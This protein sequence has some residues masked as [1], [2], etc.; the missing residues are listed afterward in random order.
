MIP[1]IGLVLCTAW[2][3]KDKDTTDAAAPIPKIESYFDAAYVASTGFEDFNKT[4][5]VSDG[6]PVRVFK[7]LI[8]DKD[9]IWSKQVG[10]NGDDVPGPLWPTPP[11]YSKDGMGG[12]VLVQNISPNQW[13][14]KDFAAVPQPYDVYIVLRENQGVRYEG[15]FQVGYGLRDRGSFLEL[16]MN[17]STGGGS[18]LVNMSPPTIF[19]PYKLAI[20]R[21]R[22]DGAKSKLW[23]NDVMIPPGEVNLGNAQLTRLGYGTPSHADQHD[24]YGMWVKFGTLSDADHKNIYEQLTS[25]YTPNSFPEFPIA[26]KIRMDWNNAGGWNASYTYYSPT[27]VAEDKSKTE[28]KWGYH[29]LGK[30]LNT[31]TYLQG[32]SA[33]TAT[34]LRS[35]FPTEIPAPHD[36]KT[37]E[38][39]VAVKVYDVNGKSW[40]R[41]LRSE[42]L[43]DNKN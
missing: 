18:T 26:N 17:A 6:K 21:L 20:V 14:S 5:A 29:T 32:K 22:I 15:Y 35:D 16:A 34:L 40:T 37:T 1:L 3:C 38:I 30:D 8:G 11:T 39:F 42:F 12:S 41:F 33:T 13:L 19:E 27:G 9:L 31:V 43:Q 4:I 23:I 2:S 36:G 7:D 25:I 28:Y 24:F 10:V